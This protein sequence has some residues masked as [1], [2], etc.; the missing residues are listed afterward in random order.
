MAMP[1]CLSASLT[2]PLPNPV[3]LL[4]L[5]K[6]RCTAQ[7]RENQEKISS[8]LTSYHWPL[9][10]GQ[11]LTASLLY[12]DHRDVAWTSVR[13]SGTCSPSQV[14][15]KVAHERNVL[16]PEDC[17][18]RLN[19]KHVLSSPDKQR[20]LA[21]TSKLLFTGLGLDSNTPSPIRQHGGN[22]KLS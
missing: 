9:S 6:T 4:D 15:H 11:T 3:H 5:Q 2:P 20:C 12:S 8:Q 16:T 10:S 14:K 17:L 18:H 13:T 21:S 7:R 1:P 19:K 22:V